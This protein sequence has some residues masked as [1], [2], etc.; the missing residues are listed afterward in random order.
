MCRGLNCISPAP[1]KPY[2]Y[3]LVPSTSLGD[4]EIVFADTI[5]W[6][7]MESY[8]SKVGP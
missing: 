8:W 3:V 6:V 1:T 2:V 5:N 4:L 7:K